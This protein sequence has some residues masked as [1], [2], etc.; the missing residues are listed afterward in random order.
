YAALS[1]LLTSRRL[2]G[3]AHKKLQAF[4][5]LIE[6]LRV[7]KHELSPRELAERVLTA[8]GYRQTLEEDDSPE[9]DARLE[10]L[11]ELLG[12]IA[13]YEAEASQTGEEPTLAGYLERVSLIAAVDTMQDVPAV[14][15][16]S[17]HSA[18]G[19]EFD[20]VWLTGMEEETFPYRGLDGND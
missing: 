6:E 20:T 16:M 12:S 8:T 2:G 19:L 9:S 7:A 11:A 14:S 1:A 5:D 4:V 15:L 17:V 13:E 3:A 18:K 10:N